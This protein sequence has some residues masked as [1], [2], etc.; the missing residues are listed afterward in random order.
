MYSVLGVMY[1][2]GIVILGQQVPLYAV[3]LF[4]LFCKSA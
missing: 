3:L 1:A 2:Q 4:G